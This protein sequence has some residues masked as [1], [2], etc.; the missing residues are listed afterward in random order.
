MNDAALDLTRF[1]FTVYEARAYL[2]LL[3]KSPAIGYEVSR[4]A[5]IPTAKIYETLKNLK[6]KGAVLMSATE[7]VLYC[8]VNP[9]EL[10]D[11]FRREFDE[12]IGT[13]DGQLRAVAPLPDIDVVW[14]LTGYGAALDRLKSVILNAGRALLVSLWPRE[15]M[16]VREQLQTAERNGVLVIAGV[17]GK[18]DPGVARTVNM[19]AC[20]VSSENR[21][22]GRLNAAAADSRE[23]VLFET[24]ENGGVKGVWTTSPSIVLTAKEYIRHDIWGKALVDEIG[25]ER[26]GAMCRDSDILSYLIQ[27]R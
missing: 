13:L 21:L 25:K 12:R 3:Q 4:N 17:F 24:E 6:R 14:N 19:D 20:G 11:R 22:G 2:A 8:P 23:A 5:N 10:L 15:A 7:P 16:A 9:N 18:C 26:F 27:T 1:G